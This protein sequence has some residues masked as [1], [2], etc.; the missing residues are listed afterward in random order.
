[1]KTTRRKTNRILALALAVIM[2]TMLITLTA[3]ES[4]SSPG[5]SSPAGAVEDIGQGGK[6]F[7]FEVTDDNENVN[8][9]N[10]HTDETI[11]GAALLDV[12][13]IAGDETAFGL[14][15]TEVNGLVA[16]F[17]ANQSWWMLLIDGEMA[18][19]G[20]DSIE[21]EPDVVYAFVYTID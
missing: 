9:W 12:G 11:L 5:S 3:C 8:A 21:I 14:M 13:L 4:D 18:M 10:V 7:R 20:V 6:V 17:N 2:L 16:D 15:V 1:M 19:V